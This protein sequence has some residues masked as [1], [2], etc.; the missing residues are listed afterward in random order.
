MDKFAVRGRHIR[1]P[2]A[3]SSLPPTSPAATAQRVWPCARQLAEW[4][5]A[6]REAP[7]LEGRAVLEL[8]AG[9]GLSG[10]AAWLAGARQVCL[11]E[12]AENVT[13]LE[14]VVACNQAGSAVTVA[15]LDWT[16][17]LPA[18]ISAA[19]WDLIVAADCVFW[20]ELFSPL[21]GT[22]RALI[23]SSEQQGATPRVILSMTDRAG[24][25]QAFKDTAQS[26]GY[27][28]Q[29]LVPLESARPLPAKSLEA[30]RRAS[31]ELFELVVFSDAT[32]S[33]HVL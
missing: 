20:P 31:C 33:L 22:I 9:C 27:S 24:R 30:M 23:E 6:S 28:L 29:P 5:S 14:E 3:Q 21:L 13:R 18:A 11:T 26:A 2:P 15:A 8:G 19:R 10:L 16:Q 17:P 32:S 25:L 12:L 1:L 7:S 4:L